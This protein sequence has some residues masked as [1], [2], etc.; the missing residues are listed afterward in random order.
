[1][2]DTTAFAYGKNGKL[3]EMAEKVVRKRKRETR[4]EG[5]EVIDY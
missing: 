5:F 3:L 4:G 1:M 2:D